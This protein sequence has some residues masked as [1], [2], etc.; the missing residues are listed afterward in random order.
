M[1]QVSH[2]EY[3]AKLSWLDDQWNEPT[4][5]DYYLMQIAQKVVGVLAKQPELDTLKIPFEV[6]GKKKKISK[7]QATIWS[8]QRW[9]GGI[10]KFVRKTKDA[11]DE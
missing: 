1:R 4:R 5:S 6:A 11:E 7:E 8:K 9:L 3:L 10:G 2:R